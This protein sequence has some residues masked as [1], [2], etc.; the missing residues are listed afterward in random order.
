MKG[1]LAGDIIG[2]FYEEFPVKRETF[3]LLNEVS[4]FTDGAVLTVATADALLNNF[5]YAE[6]YRK[7]GNRYPQA[8]YGI[9]FRHWLS[10]K[11]AGP[12]PSWGNGAAM[13]VAP[14]AM[15]LETLQAVEEEAEKSAL[16]THSHPEGIKGA[17]AVAAAIYMARIDEPK[18]AIRAY[19]EAVYGYDLEQSFK[20]VR[21][22][23]RFDVSAPG[24]IPPAL[25]AFFSSDNF[26]DA[27]RRAVSLGGDSNAQA[28]ISG[29]VAHAFY[30]HI[31]KAVMQEIEERLPANMLT[32]LNNFNERYNIRY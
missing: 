19:L 24:S 12:Y 21:N 23:H 28:N 7:W 10:N 3:D 17:K 8:G 15:A 9:R 4:T 31:P 27:V 25:L 20:G 18:P 1:A 13:R 22:H 29:A 26:E 30:K 6:A 2:S 32:I 14:I 11:E 5:P 16:A